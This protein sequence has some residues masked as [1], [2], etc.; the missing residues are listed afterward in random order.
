MHGGK[1]GGHPKH[2]ASVITSSPHPYRERQTSQLRDH[3]SM[4]HCVVKSDNE[5]EQTENGYTKEEEAWRLEGDIGDGSNRPIGSMEDLG[6][7][8][9][10]EPTTP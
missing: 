10:Q 1:C 8:D 3:S 4:V 5:Q 7:G 6:W 2:P 9:R